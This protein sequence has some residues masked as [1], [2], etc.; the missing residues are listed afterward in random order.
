MENYGNNNYEEDQR[1]YYNCPECN[2]K[3]WVVKNTPYRGA[4]AT[5]MKDKN[6][7]DKVE[8]GVEGVVIG[9]G[10]KILDSLFN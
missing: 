1:D 6:L 10:A 4:C 5:C 9:V 7:E 8:A 2:K 3:V